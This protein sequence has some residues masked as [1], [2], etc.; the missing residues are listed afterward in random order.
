MRPTGRALFQHQKRKSS[1][2][3]KRSA[4]TEGEDED[5]AARAKKSRKGKRLSVTLRSATAPPPTATLT[6]AG[7][8]LVFKQQAGIGI[9]FFIKEM[10]DEASLEVN[11]RLPLVAPKVLVS[12]I[13]QAATIS[14]LVRSTANISNVYVV[15]ATGPGG[16][17]TIQTDGINGVVPDLSFFFLPTSKPPG[18]SRTF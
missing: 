5:D 12:E 7:T 6:P 1:K 15:P 13:A 16:T 14:S 10:E 18:S 9:P 11:I 4:V 3:S 8:T 2:K 17:T